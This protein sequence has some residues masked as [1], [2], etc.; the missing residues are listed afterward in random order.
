MLI[1]FTWFQCWF[2]TVPVWWSCLHPTLDASRLYLFQMMEKVSSV[3][4]GSGGSLGFFP[5]DVWWSFMS[6]SFER[7]LYHL[8]YRNNPLVFV[9]CFSHTCTYTRT[10]L[11]YLEINFCVN[12]CHCIDLMVECPENKIQNIVLTAGSRFSSANCTIA[13]RSVISLKSYNQWIVFKLFFKKKISCWQSAKKLFL[14]PWKHPWH[15]LCFFQYIQDTGTPSLV[16]AILIILWQ[17]W[18]VK[19]FCLVAFVCVLFCLV[20]T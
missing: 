4:G 8:D 3:C 11:I 5:S 12:L 18:V 20:E 13:G 16:C 2:S 1:K 7:L 10:Q 6:K 19:D 15:Y 9:L 14:V 17:L